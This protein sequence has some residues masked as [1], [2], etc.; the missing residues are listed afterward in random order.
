MKYHKIK[1]DIPKTISHSHNYF[2]RIC[3]SN[4]IRLLKL[5][6]SQ[7]FCCWSFH[8]RTH[9]SELHVAVHCVFFILQ[10]LCD[11]SYAII[12]VFNISVTDGRTF[13]W[14]NTDEQHDSSCVY[15]EHQSLPPD[16]EINNCT[17]HMNIE[18]L[19][20]VALETNY[21]SNMK[22][23]DSNSKKY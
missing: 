22:P 11:N 14:A 5:N 3:T 15:N 17:R 21:A 4:S 19:A 20:S 12:F 2:V 23:G 10:W 8:I 13:A 16:G 6:P 18:T 9:A 7:T 1:Y